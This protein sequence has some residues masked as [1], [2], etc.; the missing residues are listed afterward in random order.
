MNTSRSTSILL[1]SGLLV[2]LSFG[3]SVAHADSMTLTLKSVGGQSSGPDYVYPYNFSVNGSAGTIQLMCISFA[4]EITFGESWTA[5]T[6]QIAGNSKFEEAAYLFSLA[7]APGA[8]GSTIAESQWANWELFDP[9]DPNLLNNMPYG[10]QQDVR[11]LLNQAWTYV[12]DN[13]DATIYSN[14][15]IY[16]PVAGSQSTGGLPQDLIGARQCLAPEPNDLILMGSG[17]LGLAVLLFRKKHKA[18]K[19]S[20]PQPK[21]K[22]A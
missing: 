14:Y 5:T 2:L 8:S 4:N 22:H 10:Y 7:S 15:T 17:L 16:I 19:Q 11:S 21:Q 3:A 9:N 13:P 20:T 6:A 18:V 1:I 12:Q